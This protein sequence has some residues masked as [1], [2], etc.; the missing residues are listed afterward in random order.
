MAS[1]EKKT[2]SGDRRDFVGKCAAGAFVGAVGLAA[3]GS[4]C[5]LKPTVLPDPSE[6]FKIGSGQDFP[7]GSVKVFDKENVAVFSKPDGLYAISLVCTHLGCIVSHNDKDGRFDCPCHGSQFTLEGKVTRA[8]APKALPWFKITP[9]PGGQL[10]VD[11]G[12]T[13][14]SG[15]KVLV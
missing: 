15:T 3:A 13:V 2:D 6:Q 10:M 9:Q 12:L 7:V 14:E 4:L 5:G 11:K 1:D 8:P